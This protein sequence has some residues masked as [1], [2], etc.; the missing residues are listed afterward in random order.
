MKLTKKVCDN[1][2]PKKKPYK[3]ANGGGLYL[4]V[5]PAGSRYWRLK[6]RYG[7]FQIDS[8]PPGSLFLLFL[9]LCCYPVTLN[10]GIFS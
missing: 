9:T 3:L 7:F 1:A 6:Y 8:L 10:Q 5:V 2:K 4:E